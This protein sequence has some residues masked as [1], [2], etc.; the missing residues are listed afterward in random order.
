M[1]LA[2]LCAAKPSAEVLA[3]NP[4][5]DVGAS[6]IDAHF[7]FS[8]EAYPEANGNSPQSYSIY[9]HIITL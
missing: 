2:K 4:K 1:A 9:H 5:P 3:G 8:C 7:L 6:I